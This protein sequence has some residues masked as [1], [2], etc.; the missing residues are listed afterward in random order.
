MIQL[1]Q[2][3]HKHYSTSIITTLQN[4]LSAEIQFND[5]KIY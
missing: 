5:L 4:S 3:Y 1:R 2:N